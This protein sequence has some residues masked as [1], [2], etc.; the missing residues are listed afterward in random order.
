[1]HQTT[2]NAA[3]NHAPATHASATQASATDAAPATDSPTQAANAEAAEA[4]RALRR[5]RTFMARA[6]ALSATQKAGLEQYA[7]T[8][9]HTIG[10][11]KGFDAASLFGRQAPL[12]VEI[13]FGM[14]YS[15]VEMAAA[16]PERD[17]VGVEIHRPGLAQLCY[18]VGSRGLGNVRVFSGDALELLEKHIPPG[19]VDTVQLFFPDPWPKTKH[20]KRRLVQPE[21]A[22]LIR[23]ALRPGGRFHMAT[24]WQDYAEWMLRIMDA[25]PGYQNAAGPGHYAD[26]PSHRPLTKFEQRGQK[27]GHGVWDLVYERVG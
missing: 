15:L 11:L 26:R 21:N 1:M 18:E 17:F 19:S 8:L 22:E 16:M 6:S 24:D 3:D 14:G 4:P 27:L 2:D 5:V 9:L 12:T 7:P 10:E 23:K 20:F 13:G 25:Q